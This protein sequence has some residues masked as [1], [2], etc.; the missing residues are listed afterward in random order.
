MNHR[1]RSGRKRKVSDEDIPPHRCPP[2]G[3]N[4]QRWLHTH[5]LCDRGA[6]SV[7]IK[8]PELK[9]A[10]LMLTG[11]EPTRRDLEDGEYTLLRFRVWFRKL[12]IEKT[13]TSH[14][15]SELV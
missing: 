14:G 8:K 11:V 6:E 3:S 13:S 1:P 12:P 10:F 9:V 15:L 7:K 5:H 2:H 4:F